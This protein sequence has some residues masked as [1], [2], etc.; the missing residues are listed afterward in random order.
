MT[1][2]LIAS[3]WI[4]AV[5]GPGAVLGPPLGGGVTSDV[6]LVERGEQ[7]AV[8]KQVSN[9]Q[10]LEERPD[11][12][13]YEARVLAHLARTSI[14]VP[15]VLAL[16]EHGSSA[17]HP[18]MLL[19]W[20]DARP[21][22]DAAE[23]RA[24]LDALAGTAASIAALTPPRWV[25]P[26]ARYLDPADAEPPPWAA[27]AGLWSDAIDAVRMPAPPSATTFL[28]RDYHP[29]NV[30]WDG[31]VVGVVDWSQAS[32]GPPAFDAAHCRA[33]LALRFGIEIAEEFGLRWEDASGMVFEPYWDLVTCID[34]LPDWR[35]SP[36]GNEGLEEFVRH[37][38]GLLG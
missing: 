6:R 27:D 18:A 9:R 13:A 19:S 12:V 11:V 29:W 14:P 8:F 10:W 3:A 20:I 32:A 22:G 7:R 30:L 2:D 16:D 24:W 4:R 33:N 26:F 28:H 1:G 37:V 25:R 31:D 21:A 35:P 36:A 17:G 23:P 5:L 15:S 34:F 38:L